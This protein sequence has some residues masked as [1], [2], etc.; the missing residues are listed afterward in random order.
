MNERILEI[1]CVE[2]DGEFYRS[3][4]PAAESE[5]AELHTT[6]EDALDYFTEVKPGVKVEVLTRNH[7]N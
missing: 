7:L 2:W 1:Y 4:F 6:V 3:V 5:L